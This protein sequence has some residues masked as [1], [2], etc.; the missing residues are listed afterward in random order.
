MCTCLSKFALW[1]IHINIYNYS[2]YNHKL[3]VY[4][5]VYV[6]HDIV[7]THSYVVKSNCS[8]EVDCQTGMSVEENYK[9]T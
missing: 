5:S 3:S 9:N 4:M 1:Y 8:K 2:L 6:I 7:E